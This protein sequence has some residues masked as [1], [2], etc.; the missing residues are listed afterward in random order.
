MNGILSP[1]T[2]SKTFPTDWTLKWWEALLLFGG[3]VMAVVLHRAF[4]T[5]DRKSVV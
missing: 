1:K 3:G 5:S 4:D 2:A